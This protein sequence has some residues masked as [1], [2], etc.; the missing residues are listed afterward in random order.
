L[1]QVYLTLA[2]EFSLIDQAFLL[3]DA[4]LKV[5]GRPARVV[6]YRSEFFDSVV[7]DLEVRTDMMRV[8]SGGSWSD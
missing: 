1:I 4:A 7:D 6:R 2:R 3:I 8:A 5:P